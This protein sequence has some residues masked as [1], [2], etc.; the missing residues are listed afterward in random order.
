MKKSIIFSIS[1]IIFFGIQGM[2]NNFH[3]ERPTSIV[4]STNAKKIRVSFKATNVVTNQVYYS[5]KNDKIKKG[6]WNIVSWN[7]TPQ[8]NVIVLPIIYTEGS[9]NT[10]TLLTID[11]CI[12]YAYISVTKEEH[13]NRLIIYNNRFLENYAVANKYCNYRN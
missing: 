11:Q 1:V 4:M 12:P 8:K 5:Q 13:S 6:K 9:A 7:M 10:H 2:E 3:D